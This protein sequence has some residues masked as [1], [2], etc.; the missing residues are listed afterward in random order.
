MLAIIIKIFHRLKCVLLTLKC[1]YSRCHASFFKEPCN[2]P[3]NQQLTSPWNS[4]LKLQ[5]VAVTMRAGLSCTFSQ[6]SKALG[7]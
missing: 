2:T 1:H 5:L 4:E 6:F 7:E 3:T